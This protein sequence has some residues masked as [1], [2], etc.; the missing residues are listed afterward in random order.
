VAALEE[1]KGY[2]EVL[3][4]PDDRPERKQAN[5]EF[6]VVTLCVCYWSFCHP[7]TALCTEAPDPLPSTTLSFTHVHV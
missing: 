5:D 1:T 6:E 4:I 3:A 2:T 7:P